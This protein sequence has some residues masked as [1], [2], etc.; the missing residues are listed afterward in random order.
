MKTESLEIND[1]EENPSKQVGNTFEF[2]GIGDK[3]IL[4]VLECNITNKK[5]GSVINCF[6]IQRDVREINTV[7]GSTPF[8]KRWYLYEGAASFCPF[9]EIHI[10][11]VFTRYSA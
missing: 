6:S 4:M 5:L 10:P 3:V 8:A 7:A 11:Q 1:R 2:F 9:E